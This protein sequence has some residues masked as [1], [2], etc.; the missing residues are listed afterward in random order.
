M[1]PWH[2]VDLG[3]DAPR[4]VRALIEIPKGSKNKYEM[5]KATGLILVDRVLFSAVQY[6]ANYGFIPR[7]YCEDGDPLDILVL[8]QEP[9]VPLSI[10]TA[11]PIGCMSMVDNGQ[12]DD[13]IIAIHRNDPEYSHYE[14]ISQLPDHKLQE[15]K[16][17]FQDYKALENKKTVVEKL[18]GSEAARE[19]VAK[20][21]A[22][23][24]ANRE[25]L[26]AQVVD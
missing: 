2:D 10:M 15:M 12:E 21:M 20:A 3:P 19:V 4:L 13:K 16:R 6:P 5:D 23:Y 8:G 14:D 18:L 17:F 25:R 7:T 9:V 24:Q 1:N 26:R 11:R 22:A